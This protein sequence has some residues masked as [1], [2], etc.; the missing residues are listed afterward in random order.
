MI[1]QEKYK[2]QQRERLL[3]ELET[4][5]QAPATADLR[6]LSGLM[7]TELTR[8]TQ[9]W[10]A[11]PVNERRALLQTTGEMAE[12]DFALDFSALFRLALHD[13]DAECRAAALEGLWEDEDPRLIAELMQLL[14][15][16]PAENVRAAAAQ[17]LAHFVLL[18]ELQKLRPRPFELAC[19][20]LLQ[21]HR[22]PAET[23]EVKR[24]SLEAVAY[25]GLPEVPALIQAAYR[26]AEELLRIS[27]V[28]A[29]GRTADA[30]WSKY[31]IHELHNPNPAMRY[32]AAR[33]CGELG[34]REAV[35]ELI[36]LTDDADSEVQEAALW[37][38]GQIGG[39]KARRALERFAETDS[40]ALAAVAQAALEEL[41][42][43]HG[44]LQ[45]FFGPPEAFD[46]EAAA[47]EAEDEDDLL[48]FDDEDAEEE[49][50]DG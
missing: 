28:F 4:A 50:W 13:S 12:A 38:L 32:E 18:G 40:P 34:I 43:F 7:D 36:E 19:T 27:A 45:Q 21:A 29:M 42:F 9:V 39:S 35:D 10:P 14:R 37:A 11:L 23:L 3:Q 44:D 15:T 20:A 46:A 30:Q 8:L 17:C 33:A 24:R 2:H 49:A 41:E 48:D 26:A 5:R 47:W 31:T 1:N 22:D 6:L 16:D 25:A